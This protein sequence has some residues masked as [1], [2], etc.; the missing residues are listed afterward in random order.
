MV[1]MCQKSCESRKTTYFKGAFFQ[2]PS[3]NNSVIEARSFKNAN[4]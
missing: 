2:V 1:E 3:F 4:N